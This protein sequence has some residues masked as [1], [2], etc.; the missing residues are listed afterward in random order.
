MRLRTPRG[1]SLTTA[2][3]V[4]RVYRMADPPHCEY[5]HFGCAAWAEGPCHDRL[6]GE[7]EDSENREALNTPP[8]E[9]HLDYAPLLCW[10]CN[11]E[12]H[13]PCATPREGESQ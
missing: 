6:L 1:G 7:I 2:Q 4:A 13:G 12:H 3:Y 8:P 9:G 10:R 5:G 11:R